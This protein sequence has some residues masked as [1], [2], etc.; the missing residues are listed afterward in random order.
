MQFKQFQEQNVNI[1]LWLAYCLFHKGDYKRAMT[2]YKS[3][4]DQDNYMKNVAVNL[5]C[6]YFYLGMYAE[7]KDMLSEA[8]PSGLKTRLSFHLSHKL[9]DEAGLM[10]HHEQLEDVLEDQLSLAAIHYLRAHYQEAI[11]IYKRLLLNN[12]FQ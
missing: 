6:C 12:R 1:D 2:I 9:S 11:D 5:A 8:H 7:S 10:E 4:Y 3:L